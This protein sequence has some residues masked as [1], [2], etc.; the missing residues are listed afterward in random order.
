MR[1]NHNIAALNTH[2]QLA[3]N[4]TVGSLVSDLQSQIRA[5][6]PALAN[7]TVSLTDRTIVIS[8]GTQ[9]SNGDFL[10]SILNQGIR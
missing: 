8:T 5:A 3:D 2:R 10:N 7:A 6:D 9:G 4:Y 1:I